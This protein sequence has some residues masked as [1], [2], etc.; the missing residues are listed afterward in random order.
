MRLLRFLRRREPPEL[1]R[2]VPRP[3]VPAG[4]VVPLGARSAVDRIAALGEARL[5]TPD[6]VAVVR[7]VGRGWT[8]AGIRPRGID[9]WSEAF[10]RI[11]PQAFTVRPAES[12]FG[13]R[14]GVMRRDGGDV[15]DHRGRRWSLR[16]FV[17][18]LHAPWAHGPW[19]VE[20]REEM[21]PDVRRLHP[22]TVM[23]AVVAITVTRDD[24]R[25][26]VLSASLS[27]DVPRR[28]LEAL[29]GE[30]PVRD[31]IPVDPGDGALLPA[32]RGTR[33]K[34]MRNVPDW[35]LVR[36]LLI[37]AAASSPQMF[38]IVWEVM[39]AASG[40][41]IVGAWDPEAYRDGGRS[42]RTLHQ[43]LDDAATG[44]S[45]FRFC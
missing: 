39:P 44:G 18:L 13:T 5:P 30:D 34:G 35:A 22:R 23:P 1:P 25:A 33:E 14:L 3:G 24:G 45:G 38:A 31:V 9:E 32:R 41:R 21:H 15:V 43:A 42:L 4:G 12:P 16:D 7:L 27:I 26:A 6:A 36:S 8:A 11:L 2:A 19:L 10:A 29:I 20:V 17:D 28:G 40:P 37:R